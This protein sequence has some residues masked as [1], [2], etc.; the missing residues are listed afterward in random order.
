M[1]NILKALEKVRENYNQLPD[2]DKRNMPFEE[3]L[4]LNADTLGKEIIN[5]PAR[6][7]GTKCREA[8][9]NDQKYQTICHISTHFL[10]YV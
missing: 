4:W 5:F 9:I 10:S 6:P 8:V 3:Y 7:T 1:K 2:H